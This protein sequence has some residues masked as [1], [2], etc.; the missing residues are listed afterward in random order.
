MS[1]RIASAL[2][3]GSLFPC[4][5]CWYDRRAIPTASAI[6][7]WVICRCIL[8]ERS[9]SLNIGTPLRKPLTYALM[10]RKV[11]DINTR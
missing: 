2:S 4:S 6:L 3:G 10:Y 7:C 8:A 5:Y 1:D 11:C 9:L